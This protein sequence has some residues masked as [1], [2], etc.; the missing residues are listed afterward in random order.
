M[1][2]K[3]ES[4]EAAKPGPCQES[5]RQGQGQGPQG[6][7]L[8]LWTLLTAGS[9]AEAGAKI[10]AWLMA[11]P[12]NLGKVARQTQSPTPTLHA[13]SSTTSVRELLP[14]PY[15]DCSAEEYE[16][17][18]RP[19]PRDPSKAATRR[20]AV[21]AWLF[22]MIVLLNFMYSGFGLLQ[23]TPVAMCGKANRA[24]KQARGQLLSWAA[25]FVDLGSNCQV[26]AIDW[27]EK[28]GQHSVSYTGEV[29]QRAVPLTLEQIL[30]ALP[31][32]ELSGRL[33]AL[34]LSEGPM[35]EILQHPERSLLPE[36]ERP[37]V[38]PK[39]KVRAT[40]EEWNQIGA[41]CVRRNIFGVIPAKRII[42]HNGQAVVNGAFGVTKGKEIWSRK[43][44]KMLAVLRLI[45]NLTCSNALQRQ[46]TGDVPMLPFF[47]QWIGLELME[48][49]VLLW[50]A[51]DMR[52]AFYVFL[53]PEAWWPLFALEKPI[54]RASGGVAGAL[55]VPHRQGPADGVAV[56][57]R[58]VPVPP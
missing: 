53:L 17:W 40:Q 46:I 45:I 13:R 28:L 54:P 9:V 4:K 14:L 32:E 37:A 43:R 48:E 42:T 1:V 34:A 33:D 7:S 16:H 26:P 24:Q 20:R 35:R 25:Y 58:S 6:E 30:P 11:Q 29:V 38:L 56:S 49:E 44:K 19:H 15:H 2:E 36:S 10:G 52:C 12:G 21:F 51:E 50:D 23:K 47:A 57:G 55:G 31:P 39:P 41:E 8:S 5:Q 18:C 22:L 3:P 27:K